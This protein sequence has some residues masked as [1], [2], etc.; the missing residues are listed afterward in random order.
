MVLTKLLFLF[1]IVLLSPLSAAN[2]STSEQPESNNIP[3]TLYPDKEKTDSYPNE[4]DSIEKNQNK[5]LDELEIESKTT[6]AHQ[7]LIK[8][9]QNR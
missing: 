2:D 5:S 9:Q 8:P 1:S 6:H 4:L 3:F 7:P